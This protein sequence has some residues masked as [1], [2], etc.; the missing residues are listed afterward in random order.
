[1]K[2]GRDSQDGETT[3][4]VADVFV[5]GSRRRRAT[6]T[7]CWRIWT[8]MLFAWPI[9]R[10]LVAVFRSLHN[11]ILTDRLAR[12]LVV[13][14]CFLVG[15]AWHWW[16][17]ER[18][19]LKLHVLAVC[20]GVIICVG[21]LLGVGYAIWSHSVASQY[22]R[23]L[24]SLR[25]DSLE[26]I[27]VNR[28]LVEGVLPSLEIRDN[29]ALREFALC[30]KDARLHWDRESPPVSPMWYLSVD[31]PQHVE[32]LCY[33]Q[34]EWPGRVVGCMG[35]KEEDSGRFQIKAR[36]ISRDLRTWFENH[37]ENMKADVDGQETSPAVR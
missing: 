4:P 14:T 6:Y 31:G 16:R 19:R 12:I 24:T 3:K 13:P 15:L 9:E 10:G 8:V 7:E 20:L 36:F 37:V 35:H 23:P 18:R 25:E 32:L 21:A 27:T 34:E 5:P 22:L 29:E 17:P 26:K 33:Y 11:P 2:A 28:S 1:M 30:A